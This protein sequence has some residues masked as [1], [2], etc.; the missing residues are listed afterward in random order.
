[1]MV[2]VFCIVRDCFLELLLVLVAAAIVLVSV[3]VV[4]LFRLDHCIRCGFVC[5]VSLV[6]CSSLLH[7]FC[8]RQSGPWQS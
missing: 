1:M 8:I 6:F 2:W 4:R 3:V 7:T 5:C